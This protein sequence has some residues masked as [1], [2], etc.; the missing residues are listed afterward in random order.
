MDITIPRNV[1]Q[2]GEPEEARKIYVEDYVVTYLRQYAKEEMNRPRAAILLGN[3][4]ERDRVSYLFIRSALELK[5]CIGEDLCLMIEDSKWM[6][7][8]EEIDQ[9][10]QGQE[11]VG[12]FLSTPGYA[13]EIHY[14]LINAHKNYFPGRDRVLLMA[15]PEEWEETFFTMEEENLMR[16]NGYFIFYERNEPMQQYMLE[17]KDGK[18]VDAE[19][20]YSD[21]AARSFRMVVQEKRDASSQK[22]TVA[23]LYGVSTFL[24]MVI[25]VIG[26]TMINNYEKMKQVELALQNLTQNLENQQNVSAD[27]NNNEEWME[28]RPEQVE[29]QNGKEDEKK[30]AQ[31]EEEKTV[32]EEYEVSDTKWKEETMEL[33]ETAVE[34]VMQVPE[35]YT[36]QKGDTLLDISRKFYGD[37]RYIQEICEQNNIEDIDKI[38]AGEKILLP[39]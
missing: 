7:I 39:Q 17:K 36:V 38:F 31:E 24:I 23:F 10:F 34:T 25:L 9:H 19:G 15:D 21:R 1:R 8:Y 5:E 22:R 28:T 33:K 13:P 6:H 2:I 14:E 26:I 16:Q 4:Q 32:P 11:I 20:E 3:A 12:W 18:S 29:T 35:F 30:E 37:D 27:L